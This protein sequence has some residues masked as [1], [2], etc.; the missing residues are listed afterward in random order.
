[1]NKKT[2]GRQRICRTGVVKT[3]W[4]TLPVPKPELGNQGCC[5]VELGGI[6][7]TVSHAWVSYLEPPYSVVSLLLSVSVLGSAST[8]ISCEASILP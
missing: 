8:T 2:P 4:V 5:L 6:G 7:G 1:M 3:S